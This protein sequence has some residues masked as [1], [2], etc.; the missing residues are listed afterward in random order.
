MKK[1]IN[2]NVREVI[3]YFCEIMYLQIH[4]HP[5]LPFSIM[6]SFYLIN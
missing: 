3:L 6:N 1:Y 2:R 5:Q 4:N